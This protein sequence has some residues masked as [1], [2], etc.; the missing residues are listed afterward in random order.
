MV[1]SGKPSI[2]DVRCVTILNY[3]S[4]ADYTPKPEE[5]NANCGSADVHIEFY[6]VNLNVTASL[7]NPH[8]YFLEL[9]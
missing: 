2:N 6:R 7:Q 9:S 4:R 1:Q 8:V 3:S 5:A